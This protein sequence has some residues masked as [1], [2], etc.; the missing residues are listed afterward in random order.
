MAKHSAKA[1]QVW[2]KPSLNEPFLRNGA[3]RSACTGHAARL[4]SVRRA[5]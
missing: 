2:R 1:F 5:R 4:D 3:N